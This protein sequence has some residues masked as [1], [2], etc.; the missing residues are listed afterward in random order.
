MNH[1]RIYIAE[2]DKVLQSGLQT[3]LMRNG[4]DVSVFDGGYPIVEMMD[5]W[6]DIFLID[7]ELPDINGL[8]VCRWL[9]SHEDSRHIPVI[10]LSSDPYLKIL[11]ASSKADDYIEKPVLF[12]QMISKIRECLTIV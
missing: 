7:I 8:E 4:F 5:N 10:F 6:P 1:S 12:E 11:A 9:K 3:A 2:E